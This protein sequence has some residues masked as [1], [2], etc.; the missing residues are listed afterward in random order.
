M[1]DD[2]ISRSALMRKLSINSKGQTIPEVDCDNFPINLTIKE[3]KDLIRNQPTIDDVEIIRCKDCEHRDE[4]CCVDS[5]TYCE[6][7]HGYMDDNDYCIYGKRIGG[8]LEDKPAIEVKNAF[9][10]V[11]NGNKKS[12]GVK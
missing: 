3:V 1:S 2:L 5:D 9:V 8:G 4:N 10:A 6:I 11:P 12:G 7:T